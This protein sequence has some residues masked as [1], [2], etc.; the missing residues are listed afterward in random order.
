[1]K[2]IL[3]FKELFSIMATTGMASSID[4]SVEKRLGF[5]FFTD[6]N[7]LMIEMDRVEWLRSN[8]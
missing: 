4:I 6:A 7:C 3:E 2:K 5:E 1:M 8:I